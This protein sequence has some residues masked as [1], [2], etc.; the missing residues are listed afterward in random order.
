MEKISNI[1]K[2]KLS[3]FNFFGI[4]Y[5]ILYKNESIYS[6]YIGISFS[7]LM[8]FLFISILI[9][10]SLDLFQYKDFSVI[11]SQKELD[12]N[13]SINFSEF[14]F[15]IGLSDTNA[16]PL[17]LNE[18]YYSIK[19]SKQAIS[20][21]EI[22]NT[23][24]GFNVI[25][26]NI[27]LNN[28]NNL[29][30]NYDMSYFKG[31][32]LDKYLCTNP[33][34]NIS[35]RGRY[36]DGRRG[37]DIISIFIEKCKNS[38]ENNI[39]CAN[40]NEINNI[41]NNN[42]Y[43]TFY[44]VKEVPDHYNLKN[45]IQKY[46]RTDYFPI[47]LDFKK[48]YIY[49]FLLSEYYSDSGLIFSNKK[50]FSMGEIEGYYMDS[51]ENNYPNAE[52]GLILTCIEYEMI[53]NR[54]YTRLYEMFSNI[55]GI[56]TFIFHIFNYITFYLTRKSFISDLTNNI[57]NIQYSLKNYYHNLP[58]N[59]SKYDKSNQNLFNKMKSNISS[60]NLFQNN[61]KN[62]VN[63]Q[64]KIFNY[65]IYNSESKN[66]IKNITNQEVN[67][68]NKQFYNFS[69][70]SYFLPVFILKKN[71]NYNLLIQTNNYFETFM[72]LENIIP[73]IE[74]FPHLLKYCIMKLDFSYNN[75]I[76][77]YNYY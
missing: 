14:P 13:K 7:F 57:I 4:D 32:D 17:S 6:S 58:F 68:K 55:G 56:L 36:G 37:F 42:T 16:I 40:D 65:N 47:T 25:I 34:Q 3:K 21:I 64:N 49:N 19:I 51:L 72:S 9:K 26:K 52:I 39:T 74:R 76:F 24:I 31:F 12:R 5:P 62:L 71:K 33:N 8:I 30:N 10:Y 44:F 67:E 70:F 73:V 50:K 46:L 54:K 69:F 61:E 29:K 35:I 53:Y 59:I 1:H 41:L 27:T 77:K 20:P 75:E 63:N 22:N 60:Q 18:K 28:C 23:F 11:S 38:S 66:K 2:T 45:P 43:L 48:L 15:M